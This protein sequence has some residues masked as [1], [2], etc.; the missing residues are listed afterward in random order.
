MYTL[1]SVWDPRESSLVITQTLPST[2]HTYI[3]NIKKLLHW[4]SIK[5]VQYRVITRD[6]SQQL[7]AKR[8]TRRTLLVKN[9]ESW[10]VWQESD[11]KRVGNASKKIVRWI[12]I[13]TGGKGGAWKLFGRRNKGK[14]GA[15]ERER[16]KRRIDRLTTVNALNFGA[17]IKA[18]EL[19]R[20][21]HVN[22]AK[23][24]AIFSPAETQFC[25]WTLLRWLLLKRT[26]SEEILPLR[27]PRLKCQQTAGKEVSIVQNI[28]EAIGR[29]VALA[30]RPNNEWSCPSKS[31]S[32]NVMGSEGKQQ[33]RRRR[34]SKEPSGGGNGR[35]TH[36]TH[37]LDR[38]HRERERRNDKGKHSRDSCTQQFPDG[39][40]GGQKRHRN[41]SIGE[42]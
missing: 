27:N 24:N 8:W 2:P 3:N 36:K 42:G 33:D 15:R 11:H 34:R 26:Q 5:C 10:W 40:I 13:R 9:D 39:K 4:N 37:P 35:P 1:L 38:L 29:I 28:Q 41:Q 23:G 6:A 25:Q 22:V 12:D 18:R 7:P 20:P 19:E 32:I 31:R 16:S 17:G 14:R 30:V 21:S